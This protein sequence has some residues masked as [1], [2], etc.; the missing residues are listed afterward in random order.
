MQCSWDGSAS[1]P[2]C[3]YGDSALKCATRA[4]LGRIKCTVTVTPVAETLRQFMALGRYGRAD[5]I[6]N[7]VAFLASAKAQYVA[8]STLTV[9]GGAN[10]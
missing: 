8:G 10:A 2:H 3:S 5:D 6:A 1:S 9:D 7:A 4:T